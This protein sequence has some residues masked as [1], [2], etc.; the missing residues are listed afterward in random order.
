LLTQGC[1]GLLTSEQASKQYYL[2][3]PVQGQAATVV[4]MPSSRL[5]VQVS[6][7][8]GLDT[9]RILA[10]GV[11]ARLQQYSNARWPDHLPEVLASTL[12]R[13]LESSG[14]FDSVE[15][16]DRATDG[17][18]LL[19]LEA[20]EF[21]GLRDAAG[22]TSSVRV[23]LDGG[24]DCGGQRH[25]LKLRDAQPVAEQRLASVVAAHQSGLDTVTR[26]LLEH[27]ALSCIKGGVE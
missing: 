23:A 13:S 17:G 16:A 1:S 10:L 14:W 26:Q 7:I 18:W 12:Q 24:I 4:A 11:D 27:I 2:L 8:P 9:D 22:N 5:S 3:A 21:Y 6:A 25:H 15:V 20:R 19:R